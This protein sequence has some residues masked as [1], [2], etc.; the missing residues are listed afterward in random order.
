MCL[1]CHGWHRSFANQFHIKA[2]DGLDV[3][4]EALRRGVILF[5]VLC[6]V[7]GIEEL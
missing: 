3:L 5:E 7:V 6:V 1:C 2:E 4:C